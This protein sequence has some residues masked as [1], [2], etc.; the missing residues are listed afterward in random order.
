MITVQEAMQLVLSAAKKTATE[1]IN[2]D[3][4][5]G[6]VL[7]ED[8]KT[9][10]DLPPYDRVTMD[11]IAIRYAAFKEGRRSF[12]ISGVAPA[13]AEKLQ[14]IDPDGC[15]E[16]M[17]GAIMP[18]SADTV[19]RYEDIEIENN[20]A[21]LIIDQVNHN[22]NIHFQGL[23][24]NKGET[25]LTSG[26]TISSSEIGVCATVGKAQLKVFKLPK[27][28]IIS[29]GD[30]LV[31]IAEKPLPHQIRKSNV[32]RIAT[33][34]RNNGISVETDHLNDNYQVIVEKL[35]EYVASYDLVI[36]SGGVSK[37][38]FDF[39]PQALEE[40]GVKKLFHK[41]K[42]RPGKPFW[43][44]TYKDQ[45]T[46]FAFPGNPVSSFMCAQLYFK[47]WLRKITGATDKPLPF[48]ILTS[49]VTFNPDLTYFLE[50]RLSFSK[51]GEI[52]ATPIKGNGSGDLANLVDAD[53]F[54]QLPQG[55]NE[56]LKGE[57]Y[58]FISY[59]EVL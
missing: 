44:G 48:A 31:E 46:V 55:R 30:E 16:V 38:K 52:L 37:G 12:H 58:P 9:D 1:T 4:A 19:I 5:L 21:T 14:L 32:Y 45:A 17:T 26:T 27:T 47:P 59:R 15:L 28:M 36:L 25:I 53:A 3:N 50:V 2:L 39:L 49:N 56:F 57:A 34:L 40:L 51:Q 22:Q 41:I 13:G 7:A 8:I 35:R 10:R 42:Q 33:I 54:I 11:G 43:F 6:R 20:I 24:R 18:A 29:S 23:D